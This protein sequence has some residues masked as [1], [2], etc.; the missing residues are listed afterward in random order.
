MIFK[1]TLFEQKQFKYLNKIYKESQRAQIKNGAY[2]QKSAEKFKLFK[3]RILVN[4]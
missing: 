3:Y 2:R 4:N 1:G